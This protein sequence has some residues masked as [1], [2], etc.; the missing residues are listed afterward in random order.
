MKAQ[1]LADPFFLT[2][3]A[4]TREISSVAALMS[5]VVLDV[6]CGNAPYRTLFAHA[7]YFGIEIPSG[8]ERGSGKHGADL[9]Y[10]GRSLPLRDACVDH[11]LCSQVLEHVF[12][13][14]AFLAELYRVLRPGGRLLVTVPFVWDEHE[15]PYDYARYSSFGLAHLAKQAGF[16]VIASRRTLADAS[17]LVQLALAYVFKVVRGEAGSGRVRKGIVATAAIPLNLL[18]ILTARILPAN[19]DLYLDNIMLLQRPH[20][21][22]GPP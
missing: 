6:G 20:G 16:D 15:Q 4:L 9:F 13:P 22:C 18:G 10:D 5:G 2:R 7:R 19:R 17:L 21:D 3:R 14:T 11:V 8:S 1:S 12:E